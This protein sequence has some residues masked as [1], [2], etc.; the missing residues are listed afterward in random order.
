MR[1]CRGIEVSEG[2]YSGCAGGE[3]CPTCEGEGLESSGCPNDCG[4]LPQELYFDRGCY[5]CPK[6]NGADALME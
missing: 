1:K 6:C 3:D 2:E 4:A 5:W